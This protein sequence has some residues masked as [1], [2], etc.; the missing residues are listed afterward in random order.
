MYALILLA[1]FQYKGEARPTMT[2]I[3]GFE[4]IDLCNATG[5]TM[6]INISKRHTN[7]NGRDFSRTEYYCV[8]V[9]SL[10]DKNK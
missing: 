7:I 3:D 4:T 2:T 5:K 1:F 6:A 9:K 10:K 8:R